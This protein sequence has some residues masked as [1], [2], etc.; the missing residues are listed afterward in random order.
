V[1]IDDGEILVRGPHVFKGYKGLDEE[2]K[3][4]LTDDGW[5]KTGDLGEIDDDGFL[6]ITGRAKEIIVTSSGKNITPTNIEKAI[7]DSRSVSQAVV[8]GDDRPY[9]V[10]LVTPADDDTDRGDVEK[11]IEDANKRFAKIEQV[12][13]FEL[14]DRELSQDEGELTPTLKV[15][16]EVVYDHFGDVIDRLYDDDG[17]DGD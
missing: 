15:K 2:T 16:R 6:K 17:D 14:L 3:E 12:K 8:Y 9:L 5:F 1:K 11:A 10:A 4:V 13:K 7:A